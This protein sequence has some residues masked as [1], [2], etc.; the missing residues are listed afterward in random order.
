LKGRV[1]EFSCIEHIDE[2]KT[3]LLPKV[4]EFSE[5]L[6]SYVESHSKME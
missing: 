3:F 4:R 1:D 6:D 2:L 5:S